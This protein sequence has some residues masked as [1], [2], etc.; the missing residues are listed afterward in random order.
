MSRLTDVLIEKAVAALGP[1]C[2]TEEAVQAHVRPLFSR[3][4]ASGQNYL[5]THALGRPLDR[6]HADV[7]EATD[8]W[9]ARLRGAWEPWIAE[10]TRYRAALA[11]L[12][13]LG[14][15]DC[16]VP[17]TSAG[18]ALRTVLNT[19]PKGSTVLTTR[20]EFTSI[21]VVLAQ[22]AA[23]GRVKLR[24]AAP[25]SDGRWT[26]DCIGKELRRESP[27][28]LVVLSHVFYRDGRI[29]DSLAAVA[30]ACRHEHGCDLLLD[31]YHALGVLPVDMEAIGCDY[32]IGGCYKYLRGG[33]GAAFLALAPHKADG[34]P[35]GSGW[36]AMIPG[37]D[38]WGEPGP[39]LLPGGDGWLDGNP[40]ILTYYQ[41]R[42]GL[43][44]TLSVGVDRLRAYSLTQLAFLQRT[45]AEYDIAA[46]GGDADHGAFLTLPSP[47]AASI[48]EALAE[49]GIIIDERAGNLRLCPD[50][51]TT[52]EELTQA[53]DAL[54][55]YWR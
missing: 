45:L 33:P 32:L 46:H 49:E 55:P 18:Q 16:I 30:H 34:V 10:Q 21:A 35:Y 13:N 50:L 12:L 5:V 44:F 36:F 8:A 11:S 40:P 47:R 42:A 4:L 25:S 48:V 24:F 22:Y 9:S 38:P 41:A 31:S 28:S 27:V 43:A 19:L 54:A 23:L 53:A 37:S 39:E 20:D 52:R 14:R 1:G 26:P 7:A 51:L 2:L 6:I 17:K 15:P 29:F 3:A